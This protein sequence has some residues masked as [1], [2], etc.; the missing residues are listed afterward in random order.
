MTQSNYGHSESF[1]SLKGI[2]EE[3]STNLTSAQYLQSL[4]ALQFRSYAPIIR[5]TNCFESFLGQLIG[6]QETVRKR[7]VSFVSRDEFLPVALAWMCLPT[8]EEKAARAPDLLLDRAALSEFVQ[9]FLDSLVP[10]ERAVNGVLTYDDGTD[11]SLAS[12]RAYVADVAESCDVKNPTVLLSVINES[13]LWLKRYHRFNE[14]VLSK[15]VRLSIMSAQRDYSQIFKH[16]IPLN[17]MVQ[18]YCL[19]AS[20]GIDKCDPRQGV[21]TT[22][23][24]SWLL[25]ARSSVADAHRSIGQTTTL[26]SIAELASTADQAESLERKNTNDRIVAVARLVDPEGYGRAFLGLTES[27]SWLESQLN[28]DC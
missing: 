16:S 12:Q 27:V 28:P 1:A 23:I 7:K 17:D 8:R 14:A 15:Y 2:R 6:W 21:L 5:S 18:T 22:F 13:R 20:R 24:Q 3:F 19:G 26:D 9:T 4:D 10:F 11:V 25:S